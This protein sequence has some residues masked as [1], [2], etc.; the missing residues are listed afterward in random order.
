M[1]LSN[2]T[3]TAEMIGIPQETGFAKGGVRRHD[4]M[5]CAL[6]GREWDTVSVRESPNRCYRENTEKGE[7]MTR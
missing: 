1:E 3:V 4:F 5:K 2:M 7:A 6:D